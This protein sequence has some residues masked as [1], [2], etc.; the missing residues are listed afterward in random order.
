MLD[1]PKMKSQYQM[2]KSHN[3]TYRWKQ[4]PPVMEDLHSEL[5]VATVVEDEVEN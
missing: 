2:L 1:H 3:F 4:Y 5:S